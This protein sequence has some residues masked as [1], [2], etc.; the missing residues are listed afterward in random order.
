MKKLAILAVAL[1][2]AAVPVA[3][4]AEGAYSIRNDTRRPLTCG[5][6]RER[7]EAVDRLALRVGREWTQTTA[8]DGP[9]T[10]ICYDGPVRATFRLRSG[11]RYSL[12]EGPRGAL[13]LR[14]ADGQ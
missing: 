6:R 8:R 10:L 9:R 11:V 2:A 1:A 7:S 14:L 3:A 12:A 13:W 5:L 4:L